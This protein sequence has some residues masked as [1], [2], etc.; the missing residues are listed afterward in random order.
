MR[1]CLK[2]ANQLFSR[3][4]LQQLIHRILISLL[5]IGMTRTI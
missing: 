2:W 1:L 4:S 5:V 3:L